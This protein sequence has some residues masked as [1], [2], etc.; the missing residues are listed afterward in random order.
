M[1]AAGAPAAPPIR[2]HWHR[3]SSVRAYAEELGVGSR[4]ECVETRASA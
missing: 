3:S 4:A 2:G 1:T